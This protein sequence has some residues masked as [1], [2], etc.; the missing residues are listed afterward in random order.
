MIPFVEVVFNTG[1]VPEAHIVNDDPK[2]N[3]GVTL[4]VTV[5]VNVAAN[6]QTPA[7]GVKV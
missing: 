3:A 6:A 4:G 7:V 1:T 5:T 2:L